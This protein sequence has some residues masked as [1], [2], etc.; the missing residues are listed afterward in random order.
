MMNLLQNKYTQ[1]L[2]M[3]DML[4]QTWGFLQAKLFPIAEKELGPLS[5]KHTQLVSTIGF[6]ECRKFIRTFERCVGRPQKDRESI[7]HAF[8]AK[9]IFNISQTK[10]LIEWIKTDVTL[11]RICG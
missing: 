4:S 8:I 6:A 7:A 10:T 9:A 2:S 11:R 3:K 5:E 1:S